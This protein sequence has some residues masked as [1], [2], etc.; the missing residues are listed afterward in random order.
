[1][2]AVG[3]TSWQWVC[4]TD[5]CF[6]GLNVLLDVSKFHVV[7]A[8]DPGSPQQ[9]LPSYPH[10]HTTSLIGSNSTRFY[11]LQ[12]Q[13]GTYYCALV[14]FFFFLDLHISMPSLVIARCIDS[15]TFVDAAQGS[16][17]AY[18][19]VIKSYLGISPFSCPGTGEGERL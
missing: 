13:V 19:L 9:S 17:A 6:S 18:S 16:T 7:S 4:V 3:L 2:L 8:P 10:T 14:F 15:V 1:M 5:A 12:L 11:S